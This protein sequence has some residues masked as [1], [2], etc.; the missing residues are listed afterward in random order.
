MLR[1]SLEPHRVLFLLLTGLLCLSS[2]PA[3]AQ[4]PDDPGPAQADGANPP[5]F[6]NELVDSTELTQ[7]QVDQMR[8]DVAGWGNIMISTRLAEQMAANSEGQLS[9]ADALDL[10]RQARADGKGFGQIAHENDLKVGRGTGDD[11]PG[12]GAGDGDTP[13]GTDD[14]E[15][16]D[17]TSPPPFIDELVEKTELTIEQVDQMRADGAGWGNIMISTRLAER[18]AA[19]SDGQLSFE[20][21]LNGVLEARAEG[22]GYGEIAHEND[23][24]LGRV[25]G[26]GKAAA[27]QAGAGPQAEVEG[28]TGKGKKKGF[29][30]RLFGFLRSGNKGKPEKPPKADKLGK[31][32]RPERPEK[33]EKPERPERPQKLEKPEKPEKPERGPRR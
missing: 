7:D 5:R 6:I 15:A 22:K 3:M 1:T 10:V 27:V 31:P 12:D 9:F 14:G 23:L 18:I 13:D 28:T 21:A 24:K 20:D 29:L 26:K 16:P 2:I 19:D 33:P 8:A 17:G 11:E 25:V 4:A 30:S 32:Q